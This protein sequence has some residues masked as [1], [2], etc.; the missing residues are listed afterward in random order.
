MPLKKKTCQSIKHELVSSWDTDKKKKRKEKKENKSLHLKNKFKKCRKFYRCKE[1]RQNM[2]IHMCLFKME[3][4]F[5][6][7]KDSLRG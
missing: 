7:M 3:I 1:G 6:D 4:K 2:Y 5:E